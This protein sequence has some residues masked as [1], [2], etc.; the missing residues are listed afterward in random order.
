MSKVYIELPIRVIIIRMLKLMIW[1]FNQRKSIDHSSLYLSLLASSLSFLLSSRSL[2][3]NTFWTIQLPLYSHS[4]SHF[5]IAT[6]M[7]LGI[8]LE[9]YGHCSSTLMLPLRCWS[10]SLLYFWRIVHFLVPTYHQLVLQ[11][12][13]CSIRLFFFQVH[14]NYWS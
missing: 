12:F 9:L 1:I 2:S 6:M 4:R 11:W 7:T 10:L 13:L 8:L 3:R 5:C 14:M